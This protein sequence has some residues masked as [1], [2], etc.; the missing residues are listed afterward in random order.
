MQLEGNRLK[1]SECRVSHYCY[2]VT[3][4]CTGSGTMEWPAPA[5]A[6]CVCPETQGKYV[7]TR[8]TSSQLT[9]QRNYRR[10]CFLHKVMMTCNSLATASIDL[11][12]A[13]KLREVKPIVQITKCFLDTNIIMLLFVRK[14]LSY[15]SWNPTLVVEPSFSFFSDNRNLMPK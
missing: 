9:H 11:L 3:K 2:V 10:S 15:S 7:W 12:T 14:W 6:T 13:N 4:K 8:T 1:F 5:P